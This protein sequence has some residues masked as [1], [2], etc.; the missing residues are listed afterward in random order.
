MRGGSR[1]ALKEI[2]GHRDIK[3]TLRYAHLS[4]GH[5]RAEIDKTAAAVSQGAVEP[6]A[7]LKA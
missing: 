7:S 4:P 2:L 3:M 6:V 1:Q 5:L